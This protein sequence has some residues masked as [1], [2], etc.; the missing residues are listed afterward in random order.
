MGLFDLLEIIES[1]ID[2][3]EA[4]QIIESALDEA[5]G[6]MSGMIGNEGQESIFQS[7]VVPAFQDAVGPID[8]GWSD[9]DIGEYMDFMGDIVNEGNSIMS[10][11]YDEAQQ[12]LSEIEEQIEEAK[13][14]AREA[15]LERLFER[16][17]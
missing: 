7:Y 5:L 4:F 2:I 16:Y 13:E 9:V 1:A 11:A 3:E 14:E 17:L 6:T 10:A 8:E 15:R 12:I